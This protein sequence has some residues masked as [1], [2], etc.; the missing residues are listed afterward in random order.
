MEL[1]NFIIFIPNTFF[2]YK[3][4]FLGENELKKLIT[5]KVI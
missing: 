4:I 1:K 2:F 3:L 5:E